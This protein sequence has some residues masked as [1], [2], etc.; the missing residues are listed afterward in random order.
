ME[1]DFIG[2]N[3]H[4][5]GIEHAYR[6]AYADC[7]QFDEDPTAYFDGFSARILLLGFLKSPYLAGCSLKTNGKWYHF[8]DVLTSFR[9]KTL[10]VL[11]KTWRVTYVN[12]THRLD[13]I[14]DGE[15]ECWAISN[16]TTPRGRSQPS[17]IQS[18]LKGS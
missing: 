12:N 18:S 6:Y 15:N 9:H 11:E 7:N 4:N 1:G 16:M 8:N 3:G 5:W 2:M 13:V 14:I 17:I 10:Q